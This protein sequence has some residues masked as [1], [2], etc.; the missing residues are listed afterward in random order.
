MHRSE[1]VESGRIGAYRLVDPVGRGAHGAVWRATHV[2]T[3]EPVALK[4]L[5][6]SGDAFERE[7]AAVARLS[8]P[9]LLPILDLGRL[10][11]P[12]GDLPADRPWLV[13]PWAGDGSLHEA[14]LGPT[15]VTRVAEQLLEALAHAHARGVVHRDVKPANVLFRDGDALLAD[16]SVASLGGEEAGISGTPPYMA[17]EQFRLASPGPA[18][19]QY[20]LGCVLYRLLAG[21]APFRETS[22][23]G[24]ARAHHEAPVPALPASVPGP[25]ADFVR[26]LLSKAPS[27]R[28][29]SAG[30]ALGRLRALESSPLVAVPPA[31]DGDATLTVDGALFEPGS[32]GPRSGAPGT[33]PVPDD[34]RGAHAPFGRPSR[35]GS[36]SVQLVRLRE[37]RTVGRG[38][39]RDLL[40]DVLR[41]V[42]RERA[43]AV[44]WLHG[45]PGVGTSH[46]ARW[47]AVHAAE[48]GCAVPVPLGSSAPPGSVGIA[49][50]DRPDGRGVK[51]LGNALADA[52]RGAVLHVVAASEPPD[53]ALASLGAVAVELAPLT[54]GELARLL[55]QLLGVEHGTAEL[56]HQ[57]SAGLPARAL[58]VVA[59]WMRQGALMADGERFRLV[60]PD[61]PPIAALPSLS[62]GD[63]VL[64]EVAAAFRGDAP[65]AGWRQGCALAGVPHPERRLESL[66]DLLRTVEDRVVLVRPEMGVSLSRPDLV[67]RFAAAGLGDATQ[68][69]LWWI[70]AGHPEAGAACLLDAIERIVRARAV[71]VQPLLDAVGEAVGTLPSDHPL[72]R[73]HRYVAAWRQATHRRFDALPGVLG[74]LAPVE[75]ASI[76]ARVALEQGRPDEALAAVRATGADGLVA[77]HLAF[78]GAYAAGALGD[79]EG[80]TAL[81]DAAV[82]RAQ[83]LGLVEWQVGC[84]VDA[85]G[86]LGRWNAHS[87]GVARAREALRLA[88]Q[89]GLHEL[90]GM[91]RLNL[92]EWQRAEGRVHEAAATFEVAERELDAAG[93]IV[94]LFARL[95][96][97]LI[98]MEAGERVR[99]RLS[100]LRRV[101]ET[102]P[103]GRPP[104][105]R[106]LAAEA[107]AAHR[108]H[109]PARALA[110]AGRLA[111]AL[112]AGPAPFADLMPLLAPLA[113][114]VDDPALRARLS[115][116]RGPVGGRPPA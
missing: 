13:T 82:R 32:A 112:E 61:R 102:F 101:L 75:R 87:A 77:L 23:E 73:R 76:E 8:H 42:E 55:E 116:A 68:R 72:R 99:S 37:P 26:R 27:E 45:P 97:L 107:L 20:A 6:A 5:H 74:G 14:R 66:R 10:E 41:R 1:P 35:I 2:P 64:L 59:A 70:E 36:T 49:L 88:G 53:G 24:W 40:W 84:L 111:D 90:G 78:T 17:P 71:V 92:A 54:R 89:H 31:A 109:E 25:L 63:R 65:L 80:L 34:W 52:G 56:L 60:E 91:A 4:V 51:R 58:E 46:L 105:L 50:V 28:F 96:R 44:V 39:E 114:A 110:L 86:W 83:E 57:R 3:G 16:F 62:P 48:L 81:F 94:A 79:V 103:T 29:P 22:L 19:D 106:A 38:P 93:S 21:H 9:H 30:A 113:E 115:G 7:V 47:L 85:S 67:A 12:L 98:A 15:D 18:V 100:A 11:G 69:G 108:E 33:L 43:P 95:E 104:W